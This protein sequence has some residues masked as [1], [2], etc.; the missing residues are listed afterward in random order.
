MR[1]K[2]CLKEAIT[3]FRCIPDNVLAY[4]SLLHP[5]KCCAQFKR[6]QST[7][8]RSSNDRLPAQC[9]RATR[10][11]SSRAH[12]DAHSHPHPVPGQQMRPVGAAM[13]SPIQSKRST[14]SHRPAGRELSRSVWLSV[15]RQP[16]GPAVVVVRDSIWFICVCAR[17]RSTYLCQSI[18]VLHLLKE[19]NICSWSCSLSP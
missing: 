16:C 3:Y 9:S 2:L 7:N 1:I 11:S 6:Q 8:R 15:S 13:I 12:S 4:A 5:S 14:C 18:W 10:S 19:S 17:E